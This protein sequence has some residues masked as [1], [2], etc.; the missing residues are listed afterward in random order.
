MV[1]SLKKHNLKDGKAISTYTK[2]MGRIL[3]V[4]V[5]GKDQASV[6]SRETRDI[7]VGLRS[8]FENF[9]KAGMDPNPVDSS[10]EVKNKK[11]TVRE[12]KRVYRFV[13]I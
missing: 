8:E 4:V 10:M 13:A 5:S 11:N 1:K 2:E 6:M 12:F 9:M 3:E 7:V